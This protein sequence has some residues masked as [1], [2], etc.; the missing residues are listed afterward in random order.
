MQRLTD[1]HESTRTIMKAHH[2]RVQVDLVLFL[3]PSV[4][5]AGHHAVALE[6]TDE[7]EL[8]E[9]FQNLLRHF[10]PPLSCPQNAR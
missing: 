7:A 2:Q 10:L 5:M 9:G 4:A 6:K 1:S 8:Q 3:L